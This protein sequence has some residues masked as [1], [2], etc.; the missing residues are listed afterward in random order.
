MFRQATVSD[1]EFI[2]RGFHTA[3]LMEDTPIERIQ[4]FANLICTRSDVLY[5][6]DNTTIAMIDGTPVGMITA[7]DGRYYR[8]WRENTFAIV[9][10]HMG[11]EFPGMD[12]EAV[13][14]EYY[15]DSLAVLPEHRGKGI[16]KALLEHA[17]AKG[18]EQ[19]LTVTLAVDPIN[20]NAKRLYSSLGF[21]KTDSLYIFGHTYEKWTLTR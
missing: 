4:L 21:R 11:I 1:A 10:E 8:Q 3:M 9:K 6:A 14:G 13:P 16:G 19:H 5:S 12:D 2:A 20:T 17:I 18:L 15:L 7:Y